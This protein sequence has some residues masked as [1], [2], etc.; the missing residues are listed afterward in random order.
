MDKDS[1]LEKIERVLIITLCLN[2]LVSL[3]K[4][5]LG[6]VTGVMAITADGFH[7]LGDTL[8]NVVG[9]AGIKLAQRKPDDD[10]SYGYDRF[11]EVATLLVVNLI[12]ITCF[13]VFEMGISHLISPSAI[14]L[15]ILMSGV[16]AGS[17]LVNLI[18]VIYEGGAGKR[19][20][21][22]LLIADATET[23]SDLWVSGVIIASTAVASYTGWYW[24]DGVATIFVGLL[25]MKVIWEIIVPTAKQLAD[26]QAI[27]P[28]IIKELVLATKGVKFCHA[29]RSRGD[30][31]FFSLDLHVGVD[32][33]ISIEE[34]HD[35]ICHQVKAK[36]K[37]S[38]PGLKSVLIHIE[39]DNNNGR[40]REKSVFRDKD[41]FDYH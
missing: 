27:D 32:P 7:S 12:S 1:R 35:G 34:A 13:K 30:K 40:G 4:I 2:L 41:P 33:S 37:N 23:K 6:L 8:S 26:A 19:L 21:S 29:V 15:N 24:L 28:K 22:K 9:I 3:T 39:P 18:T 11:E 17:M 20:G 5:T 16:I 38:I 36:L 31:N 25:I 14:K 10:H